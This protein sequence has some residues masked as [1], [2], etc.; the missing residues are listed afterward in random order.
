MEEIL[1]IFENETETLIELESALD[2]GLLN[3]NIQDNLGFSLLHHAV[4][5]GKLGISKFLFKKK[6]DLNLKQ[7][8]GE[9]A[10]T[11]ATKA[12]KYEFVKLLIVNGADPNIYDN[13]D[14]SPL[15][16]ASYNDYLNIVIFLIENGA[17]P[18][19]RYRNGCDA[20]MW[21]SRQGS[22]NSFTYLLQF[23]KDINHK[24][25]KGRTIIEMSARKSIDDLLINWL[26]ESKLY[27]IIAFNKFKSPLKDYNLIQEIYPYFYCYDDSICLPSQF[28]LF[29]IIDG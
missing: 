27:L 19:H 3:I 5:F 24:D 16:W 15:M 22:I 9:T 13:N 2:S 20:I 23:L 17:D 29:K 7:Q 8:H 18:Y 4:D 28:N 26:I 10:L 1:E 25:T 14:D 11:R 12:G 6:I 21:A